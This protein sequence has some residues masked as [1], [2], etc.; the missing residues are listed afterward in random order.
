MNITLLKFF[1]FLVKVTYYNFPRGAYNFLHL[2]NELDYGSI[3][4]KKHL[5]K[6]SRK[7]RFRCRVAKGNEVLYLKHPLQC[8][9]QSRCSMKVVAIMV[10]EMEVLSLLSLDKESHTFY[11]GWPTSETHI[12]CFWKQKRKKRG[13]ILKTTTF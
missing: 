12:K 4:L 6:V 3:F 1:N 11:D 13:Q 2:W 7:H 10:T 5:A 9:P 8:V